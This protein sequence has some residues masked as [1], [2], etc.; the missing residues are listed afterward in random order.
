MN[1][2]KMSV[3]LFG[4]GL[5]LGSLS[6]TDK[7]VSAQ[8]SYWNKL[9]QSNAVKTPQRCDLGADFTA[10]NNAFLFQYSKK[11]KWSPKKTDRLKNT[12]ES[13]RVMQKSPLLMWDRCAQGADSLVRC[14]TAKKYTAAEA[15][16]LVS[17]VNSNH[18]DRDWIMRIPTPEELSGIVEKRCESPAA[19]LSVFP[20]T[21]SAPYWAFDITSKTFSV[22]DFKDGKRKN[23]NLNERHYLRFVSTVTPTLLKGYKRNVVEKDI[24]RTLDH[25]F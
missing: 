20:Y 25:A 19:N 1:Y 5:L 16:E 8:A 4:T 22:V 7:T 13:K 21:Q 6:Y 15:I 14:D 12:F 23:T 17:S 11:Y 18:K 24:I 3:V 10:S 2:L 9:R